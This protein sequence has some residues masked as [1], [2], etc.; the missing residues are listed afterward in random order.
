MSDAVGYL[1]SVEEQNCTKLWVSDIS[2][3]LFWDDLPQ[4]CFYQCH[5]TGAERGLGISTTKSL[6]SF[7]RGSRGSSDKTC[8]FPLWNKE[9]R[10]S[11]CGYKGFFPGELQ[12]FTGHL[13]GRGDSTA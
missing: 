6:Q 12:A 1:H 13:S 3:Q 4:Q 11:N 10:P 2:H 9:K 8:P 5:F 7:L